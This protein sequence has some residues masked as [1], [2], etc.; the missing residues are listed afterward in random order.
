MPWWRT[1]G[2]LSR[3]C[4]GGAP[5]R[6]CPA[7]ALAALLMPDGVVAHGRRAQPGFGGFALFARRGEKVRIATGRPVHARGD[8]APSP[9]LTD[10]GGSQFGDPPKGDVRDEQPLSGGPRDRTLRKQ[11]FDYI[12]N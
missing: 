9:V 11:K 3:D 7:D 2:A 6:D 10:F 12:L 4:P 1:G 8:R 5:S